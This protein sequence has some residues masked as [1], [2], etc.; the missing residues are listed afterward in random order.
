MG[1]IREIHVGCGTIVMSNFLSVLVS[2][3]SPQSL[4]GSEGC[5]PRAAMQQI[6]GS[7]V[8]RFPLNRSIHGTR[9]YIQVPIDLISI[10]QNPSSGCGSGPLLFPALI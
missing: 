10:I 6:L 8:S 7:A 9:T 1:R 2:D 3:V 5:R 4:I